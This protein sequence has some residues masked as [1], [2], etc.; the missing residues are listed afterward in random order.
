MNKSVLVVIPTIKSEYYHTAKSSVMK[1]DYPNVE[2]LV[3]CDGVSNPGGTMEG[4]TN[5]IYLP[6][7]VGKEG[8]YGHRIYAAA[9][10]LLNHD[11]VCFLDE[12][13]WLEKDHVSS[14]LDFIQREEVGWC[15]SL[16]NIYSEDGT[17]VCQ[18]NGESLGHWPDGTASYRLIDTNCLMLSRGVA[19]SVAHLWHGKWGQDRVITNALLETTF[20]PHCTGKYTLNYRLKNGKEP[21]PDFFKSRNEMNETF[22]KG[23]LPWVI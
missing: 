14:M 22:Y 13:N 20:K 12:D 7:N 11:Y 6:W 21:G 9:S 19:E 16:R 1:Q 17:F 15:Y 5:Y 23:R 18:D 10:H 2:R 3:V 4:D 8:Y